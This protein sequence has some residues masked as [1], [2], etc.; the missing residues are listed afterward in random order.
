LVV[1]VGAG[2]EPGCVYQSSLTPGASKACDVEG[3]ALTDAAAHDDSG[4]ATSITFERRF[5]PGSTPNAGMLDVGDTLLSKSVIAL[6]IGK[7]GKVASCKVVSTSGDS[8]PN[9]GCK[10]ARAER[11]RTAAPAASDG[12]T[13]RTA[14]MTILVYAHEEHYA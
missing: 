6:A 1:T 13:R 3:D 2:S 5:N 11:F 4:S 10:E 12:A 7:D 9:Y 8:A 14:T